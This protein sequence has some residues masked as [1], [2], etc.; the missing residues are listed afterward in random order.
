M[1]G[2]PIIPDWS[3]EQRSWLLAQ[4]VDR[5]PRLG[6]L[7]D[8][9]AGE[10]DDLEQALADLREER[11]L[12]GQ[13]AQL[14]EIGVLL[15]WPREPGVLDPQYSAELAA[16]AIAN[17]YSGRSDDMLAVFQRLLPGGHALAE[18]YPLQIRVSSDAP[19]SYA[20]GARYARIGNRARSATVNFALNY[21]PAG[22]PIVSFDDDLVN[23]AVPF[24]EE[25][26]PT[27]TGG[28]FLEEDS[29]L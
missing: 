21:A 16:I 29:G 18:S 14:D 4:F 20:D 6:A 23:P 26:N 12:L 8:V 7:L 11:S 1:A 28:V 10:S 2:T 24:A 17:R 25:A 3:A 22:V 9:F 13:G 15:R 19:L 5:A 27:T